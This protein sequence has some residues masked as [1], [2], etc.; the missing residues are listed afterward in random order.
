M[1]THLLFVSALYGKKYTF[2]KKMVLGRIFTLKLEQVCLNK[3]ISSIY[4]LVI[5]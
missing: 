2:R 5:S 4:I 1:N 3:S